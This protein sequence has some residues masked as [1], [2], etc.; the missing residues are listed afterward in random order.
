MA[1][2]VAD[3]IDLD[4]ELEDGEGV[5]R[6]KFS[7]KKL[8]LFVILPIV[9]I[10]GG[11]IGAFFMGAFDSLLGM[12]EHAGGENKTLEVP[13]DV[14]FFDLPEMVVNLN[15]GGKQST[16]LKI[17]V[18]LELQNPEA[19]AQLEALMPRIVDQFQVYLRELRREDLSGSA[20]L[21]RI[22]E[23]LL[24]RVNAAVQPFVINDVLFK[25]FIIQ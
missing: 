2:A 4:A 12:D 6:R 17:S 13:K 5:A 14:S 15:T 1:D 22:K 8:V 9:L 24:L 7:G 19:K 20:G 25:E 11:V 23:E 16:Y 21:Y 3:D 10:F 18:A